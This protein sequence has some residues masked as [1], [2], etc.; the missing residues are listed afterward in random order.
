[1]NFSS[2]IK[3]KTQPDYSNKQNFKKVQK[4][5]KKFLKSLKK[6]F[7]KVSKKF[8]KIKKKSFEKS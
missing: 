4:V 6:V 5:L 7:K 3:S 2:V 8:W 1:M